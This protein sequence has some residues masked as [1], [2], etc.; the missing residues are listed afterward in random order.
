MQQGAARETREE[1]N[2]RV[3]VDGL[4]AMFNLPHIDQVYLLFRARLLD[5]DF[6]PGAESLEVGL[7]REAEVPWNQIAFPV[8]QETLRLYFAD[9]AQGG[10]PLRCGDIVRQSG[11]IRHY[12][13]TML[14]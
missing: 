4:Y 1:A 2:A 3:D 12:R 5:L 9:R 6:G 13:L 11:D 14:T 8:V 7:Y 10:F